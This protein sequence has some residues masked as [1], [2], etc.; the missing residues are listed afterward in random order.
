MLDLHIFFKTYSIFFLF[1]LKPFHELWTEYYHLTKMK[2]FSLFCT[3]LTVPL[4][5]VLTLEK[6]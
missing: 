1:C 5:K 4:D 6:A 2:F 3:H